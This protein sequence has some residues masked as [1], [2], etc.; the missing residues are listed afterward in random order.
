V[1]GLGW[2][3]CKK[4]AGESTGS[5]FEKKGLSPDLQRTRQC[6]QCRRGDGNPHVELAL[7]GMRQ[8]RRQ[9]RGIF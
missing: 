1:A 3:S 6:L 8:V 2:R 4:V 7:F 9:K 5:V